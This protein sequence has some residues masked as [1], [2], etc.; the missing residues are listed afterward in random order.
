VNALL[1]ALADALAPYLPSEGAECWFCHR[2]FGWDYLIAGYDT[3][4]ERRL[5]CLDCDRKMAQ[6][7]DREARG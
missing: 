2:L 3:F 1:R 4:E 5:A 6:A 7:T